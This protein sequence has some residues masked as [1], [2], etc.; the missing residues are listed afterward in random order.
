MPKHQPI[1]TC[2]AT[3]VKKP[4]N[5]LVRLVRL[6]DEKTGKELVKVDP[7]GKLRGRGASLDATLEAFDLALKKKA[8]ERALKLERKLT[9]PETEQ[10]RT[11]FQEVIDERNFRQGNKVVRFKISKEEL[12]AKLE[13]HQGS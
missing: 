7:K 3:G 9:P 6:Q 1:R 2:I 11:D 10:L 4:K 13:N 5:E 12:D 8:I